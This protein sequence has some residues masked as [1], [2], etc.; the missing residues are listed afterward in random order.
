MAGGLSQADRGNL[1]I[2]LY[3]DADWNG[4]A[5]TTASTS[6]MWA[7]LHGRASGGTWPLAW[8]SRKQKVTASSTCEA[9]TVSLSAG[10]RGEGI[11]LQIMIGQM[12]GCDISLR[13]MEDNTQTISAVRRGYSKKLR[14]LS[15]THR[16]SLGVINECLENPDLMIEIEYCP[17]AEHKADGLTKAM[18][19]PQFEVARNNMNII[20]EENSEL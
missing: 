3:T 17:T 18:G 9:E 7:E 11:P 20:F 16:V 13:C 19:R 14:Q 8:W 2:R 10:L 12:L 1:E 4:D 5:S 6:G 15:R